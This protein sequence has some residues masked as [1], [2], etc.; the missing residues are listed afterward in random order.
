M[1]QWGVPDRWSAPLETFATKK[2]DCEDYAIA[3]YVALTEA[4]I[5]ADD[6]KLIIIR[7]TAAN[8]DHAVTAVRL[9]GAWIILDNRWLSLVEDTGHAASGAAVRARQRRRPPIPARHARRR[10]PRAGA[11]LHRRIKASYLDSAA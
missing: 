3:K 5:A 9:D 6:V 8:E 2:G 4:G 7:N 11:G 1:A 10:A